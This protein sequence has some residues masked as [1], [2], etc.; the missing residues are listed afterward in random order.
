MDIV[1]L[2]EVVDEPIRHTIE[3]AVVYES[4]K[5]VVEKFT[6]PQ[7]D[8]EIAGL[9]DVISN[10]QARIDELTQKKASAVALEVK[11]NEEEVIS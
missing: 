4:V 11:P 7:I 2:A 6:I 1:R 5:E 9:Q 10:Y 8:S 3:K